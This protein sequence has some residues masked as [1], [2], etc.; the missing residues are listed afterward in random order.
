MQIIKRRFAD[1][2][3]LLMKSV[4]DQNE[5]FKLLHEMEESCYDFKIN[6]KKTKVLNVGN[7]ELINI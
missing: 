4:N 7:E 6:Q 5:M 3:V 2:M 1:N